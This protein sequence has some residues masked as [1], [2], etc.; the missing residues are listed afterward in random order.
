MT[1]KPVKTIC[2]IS[3]RDGPVLGVEVHLDFYEA[4]PDGAVL[5]LN[6]PNCGL[7]EYAVAPAKV[8]RLLRELYK[9][10]V[11]WTQTR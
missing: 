3:R 2:L 11:R 10:E 7:R 6:L 9:E 5:R 8:R 1:E 4:P